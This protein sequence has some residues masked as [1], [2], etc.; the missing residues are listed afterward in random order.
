MTYVDV[1]KDIVFSGFSVAF[2]S[3]SVG[4]LFCDSHPVPVLVCSVIRDPY[5]A[6]P[7][8]AIQIWVISLP[9]DINYHV[10]CFLL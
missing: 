7:I 8:F 5:L 10:S 6:P 4:V 2:F 1:Q 9:A 3:L